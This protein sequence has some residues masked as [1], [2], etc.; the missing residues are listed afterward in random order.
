MRKHIFLLSVA[1]IAAFGGCTSADDDIAT[2]NKGSQE[3]GDVPIQLSVQG[4][5]L[6]RSSLSAT[7]E[8]LFAADSM[9]VF[10]LA[11]GSITATQDYKP[12]DWTTYNDGA[13]EDGYSVLM[14]NVLSKAVIKDSSYTAIE[15]AKAD[16]TYFYPRNSQYKYGFAGY[17]PYVADKS[18]IV[19]GENSISIAYDG[20]DGTQDIIAGYATS[21]EAT[22]YSATYFHHNATAELPQLQLK[23][24]MA[25]L[26]FSI[27]KD[28]TDVNSGTVG[29]QSIKLLQAPSRATLTITPGVDATL[30]TTAAN[31]DEETELVDYLLKEVGNKPLGSDYYA[32]ETEMPV[33][34]GFL[35]PLPGGDYTLQV[36]LKYKGSTE[37]KQH[38]ITIHQ[39]T[40]GWESGHSYNV[41]LMLSTSNVTTLR[42]NLK[43]WEQ[44]EDL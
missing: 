30:S 41:R 39:P 40:S 6:T 12:I 28:T 23:H 15:W 20:L 14:S 26:S 27:I 29:I 34:Q 9:G 43:Q 11:T 33:G 13:E 10:C 18:K 8:G 38:E 7:N 16:T 36:T 37:T 22:A 17:F 24:L 42:A 1:A 32:T 35:V 44:G 5:V 2:A 25:R 4:D 3:L 31:G 19:Y 21:N